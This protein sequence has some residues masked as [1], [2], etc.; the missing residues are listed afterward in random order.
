M[1]KQFINEVSRMKDLFGYKKGVVIS[2]QS[3]I[4]EDDAMVSPIKPGSIKTAINMPEI[5]AELDASQYLSDES[6]KSKTLPDISLHG[7]RKCNMSGYKE[8]GNMECNQIWDDHYGNFYE[9]SV[10][11]QKYGKDVPAEIKG[12]KDAKG[13]EMIPNTDRTKT[14]DTSTST[15]NQLDTAEK[16]GAFQTWMDK[17]HPNW[18]YSQKYKKNY[19]VGGNPKNGFGVLGP[20]TK[21]AWDNPKYKEEYLKTLSTEGNNSSSNTQA[22]SSNYIIDP[23]WLKNN[24]WIVAVENKKPNYT[25]KDDIVNNTVQASDYDYIIYKDKMTYACQGGTKPSCYSNNGTNVVNKTEDIQ[26]AKKN[27]GLA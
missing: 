8:K 24:G 13:N 22:A 26:S 5:K 20:N 27:V 25:F 1:S 16:I 7:L 6:W 2:E 18:A 19:N 3:Y 14:D 12:T 4:H 15:N 17:T 11:K 23:T 10:W 21:K 9:E